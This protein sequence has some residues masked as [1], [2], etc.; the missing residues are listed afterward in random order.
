MLR[1]Q[2]HPQEKRLRSIGRLP[3]PL[4][5]H[6]HLRRKY[7][8]SNLPSRIRHTLRR[9]SAGRMCRYGPGG[10]R[11]RTPRGP[12]GEATRD[13]GGGGRRRRREGGGGGGGGEGVECRGRGG[14][15]SGVRC[16]CY[17]YRLSFLFFFVSCVTKGGGNHRGDVERRGEVR[18]LSA[19][20][21]LV[22]VRAAGSRGTWKGK[23]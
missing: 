8:H 17:A 15:S 4:P 2:I 22:C 6:L 20:K 13:R 10:R 14:R 16:L 11:P 7:R 9:T 21:G 23:V 1:P 18:T 5:P 3:L 12:S 19:R